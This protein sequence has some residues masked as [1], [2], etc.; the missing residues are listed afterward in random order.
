MSLTA[1]I[2]LAVLP[3]YV[4][5]QCEAP[6]SGSYSTGIPA[7]VVSLVHPATRKHGGARE[8]MRVRTLLGPRLTCAKGGR[9]CATSGVLG[10][11]LSHQ[12]FCEQSDKHNNYN[13]GYAMLISE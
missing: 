2:Y 5:I 4:G 3:R 9:V 13:I 1:W 7:V 11:F 6:G 12:T 10:P 8:V